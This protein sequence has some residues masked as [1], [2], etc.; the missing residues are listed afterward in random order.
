MLSAFHL[1]VKWSKFDPWPETLCCV[2]GATSLHPRVLMGASQ[3][4]CNA[5]GNPV[6]DYHPIQGGVQI[7]Q[8]TSC[9]WNRKKLQHGTNADFTFTLL[10]LWILNYFT[11]LK[12]NLYIDPL[13]PGAFC[14]KG[15][16]LDILVVFRLDLGQTSFN[17]VK[18]ALASRQLAFPAC[19]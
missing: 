19:H 14:E 10:S 2:L 12:I 17:L 15:I 1:W 4:A 9:C 3:L 11:Y 13:T 5:G 8:V 18:N 7:V 6:M 16:F